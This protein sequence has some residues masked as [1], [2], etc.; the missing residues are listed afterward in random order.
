MVYEQKSLIDEAQKNQK[1]LDN[2]LVRGGNNL[3]GGIFNTGAEGY[4]MRK[5][6]RL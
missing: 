3:I 2:K 4:A 5:S 1:V 6:G